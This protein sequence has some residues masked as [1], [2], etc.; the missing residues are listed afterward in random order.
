M[1]QLS[2]DN[3]QDII[4]VFPTIN[5]C[6]LKTVE[7]KTCIHKTPLGLLWPSIAL[8]TP[9]P[10][11]SAQVFHVVPVE[12]NIKISKYDQAVAVLDIKRY[13]TL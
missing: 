6:D 7:I 1:I 11:P 9:V 12:M 10:S 13:Q 8:P 2:D 4:T 3:P 5:S